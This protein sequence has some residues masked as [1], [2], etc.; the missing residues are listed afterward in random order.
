MPKKLLP[1]NAA[2]SGNHNYDYI[3]LLSLA[4]AFYS[5]GVRI[6]PIKYLAAETVFCVILGIRYREKSKRETRE[7]S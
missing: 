6:V 5:V 1:G 3:G 4:G 7:S 2:V